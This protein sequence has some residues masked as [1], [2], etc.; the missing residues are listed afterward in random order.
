MTPFFSIIIPVYNGLTHG[1]PRCID[2]IYSQ[3]LSTDLYEVLC[4]DDCSTDDT[5]QWLAE[6]QHKHANLK[7]IH[8]I[9]NT[10]QGGAR[11]HGVREANGKYIMFIDQDDYFHP[12]AITQVY[13]HLQKVD[14][15]VLI[16]DCYTISNGIV[17]ETLKHNLL[18]HEVMNGDAMLLNNNIPWAPWKFI[19]QR[20]WYVNYGL[21]FH[22]NQRIEDV[23]W[24]YKL[25]HYA[26][27]VQYQPIPVI[28]YQFS[29]IS[30]TMTAYKNPETVYSALDAS[31]R[32][33]DLVDTVF[34]ESTEYLRKKV[35]S[36]SYTLFNNALRNYYF[37]YDP[38]CIKAFNIERSK[39]NEYIHQYQSIRTR[40]ASKHPLFFSHITNI[41]APIA[42]LTLNLYRKT[43]ITFA[44]IY[45]IVNHN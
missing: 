12:G 29:S 22:E 23:D 9:Q 39:N 43:R 38:V 32:V 11:N 44:Y 34:L 1:L 37:F 20:N 35:K 25:V 24:A 41:I 19:I 21:W 33:L 7:T 3:P 17:N 13:E 45:H 5:R 30:T 14:L 4:V 28:Y 10:R 6:Q 42:R 16:V 36:L 40:M 2:S 26:N 18:H 15:D 8:N 31:K 27:K